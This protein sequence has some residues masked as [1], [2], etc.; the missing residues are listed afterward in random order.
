MQGAVDRSDI[1]KRIEVSLDALIEQN[2]GLVYDAGREIRRAEVGEDVAAEEEKHGRKTDE[3]Y[4]EESRARRAAREKARQQEEA[5]KR[6]EEEKEKLKVEEKKKRLELE[7]LRSAD[8]KRRED[9]AREEQKEREREAQRVISK[10]LE[11]EKEIERRERYERRR[12][13][14]LDRDRDGHR[15]RERVRSR[16]EDT[17][18]TRTG[19]AEPR[20]REPKI[21]S[22]PTPPPPVDEKALE[23]AALELLLREGRELAAKSGS[24]PDLER[25]E[26]LDPPHRKAP[27]F[28][29]AKFPERSPTKLGSPHTSPLGKPEHQSAAKL[30]FSYTN[31]LR[32]PSNST[33]HSHSRS[34]SRSPHPHHNHHHSRSRSRSR[35]RYSSHRAEE[36]GNL[37]LDPK[38]LWKKQAITQRERE[39]EVYKRAAARSRSGTLEG[40]PHHSQQQHGHYRDH[41]HHRHHSTRHH[42][43][44][45]RSRERRYDRSRSPGMRSGRK[46]GY[47]SGRGTRLHRARDKSPVD[48]D[49]YVPGGSGG[50]G[51]ER[52][53][54]D[55]G[56][57]EK[58]RGYVEIDRYVPG[59]GDE[60]KRRGRERSR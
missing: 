39:A 49:R 34:R 4:A 42:S 58:H 10:Q 16:H 38:V 46:I 40:E 8:E 7:K 37:D 29:K 57:E 36:N 50:R 51:R 9:E 18:R 45:S 35:T 43:S 11:H 2:I 56:R 32:E 28:P 3:E 5:R 24:K 15:S 30:G 54:R 59:G 22:A 6:R 60:G 21:L 52:D 31:L 20:T 48:I 14:Q 26:S 41:Q 44:R 1:Y 12:K 33:P 17:E 55:G 25:S 27:H 13:E 53:R 23:E 19:D 47:D